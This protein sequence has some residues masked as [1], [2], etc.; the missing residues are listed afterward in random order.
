MEGRVS[1]RNRNRGKDYERWL[2]QDLAGRRTGILGNEDVVTARFGIEAKE[3][4][5][6]PKFIENSMEQAKRN[7]PDDKLPLFCLHKLGADHK[8]DL[9]VTFYSVFKA[10]I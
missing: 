2:A 10:I 4:E 8:D 9:V 6:I 5:K 1:K 3:R 7:C